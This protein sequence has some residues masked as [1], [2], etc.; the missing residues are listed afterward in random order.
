MDTNCP[1]CNSKTTHLF[2]TQFLKESKQRKD[3]RMIQYYHCPECDYIFAPEFK[4]WTEADFK[5]EMYNDD[6]VKYD[7]E[8]LTIRPI[9]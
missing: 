9:S 4:S 2:A 3:E 6:Y 8:F 5:R 7:P 1:I